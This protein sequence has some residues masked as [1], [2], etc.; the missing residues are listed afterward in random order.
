MRVVKKTYCECLKRNK[1]DSRKNGSL[2]L[3]WVRPDCLLAGL[4]LVGFET[5]L[6]FLLGAGKELACR[7]GVL[8]L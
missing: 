6:C 1:K 4:N 7:I 8:L 3:F 2:S 5:S